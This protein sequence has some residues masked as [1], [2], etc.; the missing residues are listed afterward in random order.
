MTI[1]SGA[2]PGKPGSAT[3]PP[4]SGG[5]GTTT[6]TYPDDVAR[7]AGVAN[8]GARL[9]YFE[10]VAREVMAKALSLHNCDGDCSIPHPAC[11][12]W[13]DEIGPI[14]DMPRRDPRWRV[15][16]GACVPWALDDL[17]RDR[18]TA[19]RLRDG[20]DDLLRAADLVPDEL[21]EVLIRALK[22]ASPKRR[23]AV[24]AQLF[25]VMRPLVVATLAEELAP[26]LKGGQR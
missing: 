11:P 15:V 6:R 4:T 25:E 18:E 23:S 5:S 21:L 14:L 24:A 12:R 2:A 22:A 13:R 9:D 17:E 3:P 10:T 1:G 7:L 8:P 20:L 26:L 19:A 16:A